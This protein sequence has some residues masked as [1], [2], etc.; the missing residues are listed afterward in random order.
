MSRNLLLPGLLFAYAVHS[1]KWLDPYQE[2]ERFSG[3]FNNSAIER[4]RIRRAVASRV[5]IDHRARLIIAPRFVVEKLVAAAREV[6][7]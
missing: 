1:P 2:R 3:G 5:T 4:N 6:R 7:S